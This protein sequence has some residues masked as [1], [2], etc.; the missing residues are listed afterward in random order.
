MGYVRSCKT[1]LEREVQ[2]LQQ[3]KHSAKIQSDGVK[4]VFSAY[5][6]WLWRSRNS[7]IFEGKDMTTLYLVREIMTEVRTKL[8]GLQDGRRTRPHN[9]G[10]YM[11]S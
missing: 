9:N 3:L 6:Y 7:K 5:I 11:G 10:E 8:A 4:L 1:A 2:W